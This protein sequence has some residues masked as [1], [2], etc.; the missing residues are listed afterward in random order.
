MK[1]HIQKLMTV[2]LAAALSVLLVACGKSDAAVSADEL[3]S[4]IGEV[5]LDSENA[6]LAAEITVDE[7]SDEDYA[8][9]DGLDVLHAARTAYD[10]LVI[11]D[12]IAGIGTVTLDTIGDVE[13]V[14]DLYDAADEEVQAAVTNLAVL[15]AAEEAAA[16]LQEELKEELR[17]KGEEALTRLTVD[18]D[19]K[20]Y[21]NVF[22]KPAVKPYYTNT[23]SYILPYIGKNDSSTWLRLRYHYTD[24]DWVFFESIIFNVDGVQ[25][26]RNFDYFDI[27]HDNGSG[28]VWEYIDVAPTDEEIDLL[29]K[30]ANSETTYV[31]FKGDEYSYDMEFPEKDKA[32]ILDVLAAYEYLRM[33]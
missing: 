22:Y 25:C 31:R 8:Q 4:A 29:R 5:T 2:L 3:I 19:D 11:E 9:V 18:D 23:R 24:D 7:L 27:V 6:I 17:A 15:E 30:I 12:R 16:E 10:A 26:T 21:N 13:D 32:A 1:K 14:R 28:D 20:I 33:E